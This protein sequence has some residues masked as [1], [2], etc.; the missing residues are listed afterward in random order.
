MRVR[1]AKK[2]EKDNPDKSKAMHLMAAR[3]YRKKDSA[4]LG[5]TH[6]KHCLVVH[7]GLST[8]IIPNSMIEA[9]RQQLLLTRY[10]RR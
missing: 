3:R 7:T 10:L 1:R 9:K 2:W 6:V 4:N 5:D 8:E